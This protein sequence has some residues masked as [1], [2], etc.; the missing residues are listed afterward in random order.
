M[1]SK[2]V[3]ILSAS[4]GS[5]HTQAAKA[6]SAGLAKHS[7]VDTEAVDFIAGEHSYFSRMLKETY[8]KMLHISP[9][10]YDV[11]YQWSKAPIPG[12]KVKNLLV[13]IMR[14]KMLELFAAKRPDLIVC[15][16][17][18]PCAAAAALK[19]ERI[20]GVPLTAAITDFAAHHLWVYPQVDAYFAA[21]DNVA[22]ELVRQ[23]V[24][25][26]RIFVTG[27]PIAEEFSSIIDQNTVSEQFR[28]HPDYPTVLIMGGGLGLGGVSQALISLS[29]I[30][31]P[32]QIIVVT[33]RNA[34]LR[35]KIRQTAAR[36]RHKVCVLGYTSQVSSLM[37]RS[38]L[39]IT[40][41]GALTVSEAIALAKPL[42]LFESIPGQEKENAAYITAQGAAVW[43]KQNGLLAE[44][45]EG[46]LKNRAEYE[47]L[48]K[49]AGQ[50]ARP[51]AA[52]DIASIIHETLY[53]DQYY[54]QSAAGNGREKN[55]ISNAAA[56]R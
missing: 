38:S 25:R 13:K 43:V 51:Y 6:I 28:L 53:P 20:I 36:V 19:T 12:G 46:L 26:D 10:M 45:V 49:N 29:T 44:A 5:G 17:P 22:N 16:H 2:K 30:S 48:K 56:G 35:H 4:I 8:L 31:L 47:F 55:A 27:I 40:K 7:G 54:F 9:N 23:D 42:V 1:T 33:G 21:T 3:L 41:P 37:A 18:F 24:K 15:T 11:L 32:L 34:A 14:K 39:I 50:I 52:F